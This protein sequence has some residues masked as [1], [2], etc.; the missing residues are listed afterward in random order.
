MLFRGRDVARLRSFVSTTEQ[1]DQTVTVLPEIDPVTGTEMQPEFH[2]PVAHRLAVAEVAKADPVESDA[3]PGAC[4]EI[5]Q[6][7]KPIAEG[8]APGLC[9]V[10][11]EFPLF[12]RH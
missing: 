6:R 1:D 3:D 12:H 5:P 11:P 10:L 7:V 9:Q 2:A 4:L 8:I